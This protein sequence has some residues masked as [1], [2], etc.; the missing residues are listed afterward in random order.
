MTVI[1]KFIHFANGL[2]AGQMDSV[3]AALSE[4]MESFSPKYEFSAAELTELDRRVAEPKP[5]F[6]GK[7]QIEAL[8]GKPFDA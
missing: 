2:P 4:L 5:Q 6:A 8:F 3:E 1:E 7:G